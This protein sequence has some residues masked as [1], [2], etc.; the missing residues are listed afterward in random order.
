LNV[1]FFELAMTAYLVVAVLFM[2]FLAGRRETL[3]RVCLVGTIVGFVFHT[4]AIGQQW[5]TTGGFPVTNQFE[6]ASFFSWTLVL[7]FLLFDF[8]YKS[9][10]LGAFVVPLAFLSV[11]S[12]AFLR[13]G[14]Q[15][16]DPGL[17]TMGLS[18]HT[19]LILLGAAAF[20][21]SFAV[22]IMYLIQMRLLKSKRFN[23]MY[24]HLPPLDA[25]DRLIA[26]GVQVGFLFTT[27][28]ILGGSIGAKFVWGSYWDFSPKQN[29]SAMIWGYYLVMLVGRHR[30]GIRAKRGAY[31]AVLG[32]FVV[33][34]SFVGLDILL[35]E[36]R[37][38]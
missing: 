32:F 8:R 10:V 27:L 19:S 20:C 18:M 29:L 16:I 22:A 5:M 35:G 11:L 33:A 7:A 34:L 26:R 36:Q 31:M 25:C 30:F 15:P 4:L 3:S 21:L 23:S 12:A 9:H 38:F 24:H 37:H 6:A 1:L 13:G 17:R 28:G 2:V 14:A